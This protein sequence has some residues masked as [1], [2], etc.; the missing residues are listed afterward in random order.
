MFALFFTIAI[1]YIN[2]TEFPYE[3]RSVGIFSSFRHFLNIMLN[4]LLL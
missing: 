1:K 4:L 2:L 3:L